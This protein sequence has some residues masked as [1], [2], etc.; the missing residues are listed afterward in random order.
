MLTVRSDEAGLETAARILTGGGVAVIPTDTVYGLAAHPDFPDAV[1]RLYQ[2]KHRAAKKPIA[3]LASD[4]E[5]AARFLGGMD[6]QAA[7][8]AKREWP[9][10]LTLVLPVEDETRRHSAGEQPVFEGLR[11]P[12]HDW[13]RRLIAKC[14]GVL[15]VTSA[16][17]SGQRAATD[18]PEALAAI[19]LSADL[20][21]DD[22][23]S[24][25]GVASTVA[26]V[27]NGEI[28]ILR[29]GPVRFL[30][31]ASG[32]P[33]RA[34]I[35]RKLGVDFTVVKSEAPEVLHP[36]DPERTVRENALAKGAAVGGKRVL[37]ADTIVW[38]GN[39]IYG[40]PRDLE[41]AKR[42]LRELSGQVHTVFTGVAYDGDVRVCRSSVRFR[43]LTDAAIDEYVARVNPTDRAGA[44]DIDDRGNT[45][46]ES[47]AGSY[48]NIMGL[49]V[50]P[51]ADWK[52]LSS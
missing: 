6:D 41:E 26:K 24:P 14:G 12:D 49:P 7:R 51:L 2:I 17:L 29:P 42:F 37:S 1:D 22:G 21:V 15:R 28:A 40:K 4:P 30:T 38:F 48:E 10:A 52:I 27:A 36:E 3:L 23:I 50:E 8:I 11:V 44:Y 13:T 35:L 20:I 46:V 31:L 25:G 34:K 43:R 39:K 5:G 9:G 33:R 32:S 19:G 18:A 45:V 16:N 47:Y